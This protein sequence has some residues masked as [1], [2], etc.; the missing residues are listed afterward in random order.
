MKSSD[1]IVKDNALIRSRYHLTELEQR[2]LLLA[3]ITA[4]KENIEITPYTEIE[5]YASDYS[6]IY[7]CS[8][9]TAY[10][11]LKLASSKLFD[12]Y[13]TYTQ[14]QGKQLGKVKSRW[15]Q[16]IT[17][18]CNAKIT[19]QLSADLIPFITDLE[20]NFTMYEI[21]QISNLNGAYAIRIYELCASWKNLRK[22][23]S[24]L[25]E[26]RD[27]LEIPKESYSRPYNFKQRVIKPSIDEINQK[28]DLNVSFEPIKKGRETIGFNFN[29]KMKN[30]RIKKLNF[31]DWV[32]KHNLA[33]T[34][35]S[36]IDAKK[37][38]FNQY[39]LYKYSV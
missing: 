11:A 24:T 3:I 25:V 2:T 38:L 39:Q 16:K 14:E 34:G 10:E 33:Y 13:F 1:L 32:Q 12:R 31:E 8:L 21:K 22:K 23:K 29:I 36:W 17:H 26:L 9:N 7:S 6:E 20:K 28:T 37:R 30:D 15:V 27:W 35:E 5:V 19:I 18:F 4:R